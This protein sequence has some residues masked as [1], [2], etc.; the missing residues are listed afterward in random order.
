MGVEILEW[1]LNFLSGVFSVLIE[2]V[3]GKGVSSSRLVFEFIV[4]IYFLLFKVREL[5]LLNYS[6]SN[7]LL[8]FL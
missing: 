7:Y 5:S 4:F 8:S 6:F 2:R 3:F 1:G